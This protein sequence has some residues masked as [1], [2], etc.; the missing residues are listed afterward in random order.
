MDYSLPGSSAHG[1]S[2]ARILGVGCHFLLQG[3]FLTQ[4]LN[5]Q[6]LHWQVDTAGP[7]GKPSPSVTFH[8]SSLSPPVSSSP[9]CSAHSHICFK[10]WSLPHFPAF[11][12]HLLDLPASPL[13][14]S[15][16]SYVLKTWLFCSPRQDGLF[17]LPTTQFSTNDNPHNYH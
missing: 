16:S 7:P 1:I 3:I 9:S 4:G 17:F 10:L 13:H 5:P 11:P 2:Q 8:R 15:W 6:L 14:L 12:L